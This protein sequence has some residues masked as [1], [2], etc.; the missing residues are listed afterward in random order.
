[1]LEEL[2]HCVRLFSFRQI[3]Y[4]L[5]V[6][7]VILKSQANQAE[8]GRFTELAPEILNEIFEYARIL[9]EL[10]ELVLMLFISRHSLAVAF[11]ICLAD[12]LDTGLRVILIV[13]HQQFADLLHI[14]R[15]LC[16]RFGGSFAGT[17]RFG[18]FFHFSFLC[19]TRRF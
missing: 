15:G 2:F 13:D 5:P 12:C 8:V 14:G 11:F 19:H 3:L 7:L 4:G 18:F 1:M 17:L 10:Q 9:V 6:T 16:C